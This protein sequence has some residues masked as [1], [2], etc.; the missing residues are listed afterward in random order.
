MAAAAADEEGK[1]SR[2]T[3]RPSLPTP[4]LNKKDKERKGMRKNKVLGGGKESA[5]RISA[6]ALLYFVDILPSCSRQR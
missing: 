4:S 1:A 5:L 2:G 3:G 6:Q